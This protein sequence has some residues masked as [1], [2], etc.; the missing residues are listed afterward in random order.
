[1]STSLIQELEQ[2]VYKP[3]PRSCQSSISNPT[4]QQV[5]QLTCINPMQ[6]SLLSE[7]QTT[8]TSPELPSKAGTYKQMGRIEDAHFLRSA[9]NSLTN[10]LTN[11]CAKHHFAHQFAHQFHLLPYT[12][13]NKSPHS[14]KVRS[15]I[16]DLSK[17]FVRL[18]LTL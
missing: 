16:R 1:M 11:S 10:S 13:T 12:L 14:S 6:Y 7:A 18:L 5:A 15:P 8:S 9:L 2:S 4:S 17:L 3:Q